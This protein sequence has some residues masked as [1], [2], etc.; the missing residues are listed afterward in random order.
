[1]YT[2]VYM[3]SHGTNYHN[4]TQV[5]PFIVFMN[6]TVDDTEV[7]GHFNS[8]TWK[9]SSSSTWDVTRMIGTDVYVVIDLATIAYTDCEV[10]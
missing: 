10:L 8:T 6:L 2:C 1:M 7:P 3:C 9:H 4:F 5:E